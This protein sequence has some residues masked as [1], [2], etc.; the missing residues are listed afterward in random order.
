KE[1]PGFATLLSWNCETLEGY[2]NTWS[3]VQHYIQENGKNPV[4][5]LMKEIR[6][7]VGKNNRLLITFPIF[8][9]IGIIRK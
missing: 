6:P 8:M 5:G 9:R 2:L 1:N 7:E 4:N 3:A